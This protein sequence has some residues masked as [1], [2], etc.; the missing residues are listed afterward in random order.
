MYNHGRR[1]LLVS[2]PPRPL[3][4]YQYMAVRMVSRES[5]VKERRLGNRIA[6]RKGGVPPGTLHPWL[7]SCSCVHVRCFCTEG[8]ARLLLLAASFRRADRGAVSQFSDLCTVLQAA[9]KLGKSKPEG[10]REHRNDNLACRNVVEPVVICPDV[11][12]ITIRGFLTAR[13]ANP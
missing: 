3:R 5:R 10:V 4:R 1:Y 9:G 2:P 7:R 13:P 12:D 11:H 6:G 8:M